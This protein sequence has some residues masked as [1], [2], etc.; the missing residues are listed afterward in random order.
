[1]KIAFLPA[2]VAVLVSQS[3]CTA[4]GEFAY[5][6][7]VSRERAQCEKSVSM[8]ERQACMQRVNTAQAQADAQRK[9]Q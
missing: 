8:P 1:M 3:A 6:D 5:D 7:A 4:I 2:A 9:K